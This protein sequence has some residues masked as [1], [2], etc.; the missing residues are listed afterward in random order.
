MKKRK[1]SRKPRKTRGSAH[2][3]NRR[4]SGGK[5]DLVEAGK[6]TRFQPGV[7]GNLAGRP[8]TKIFRQLAREIVEMVDTKTKK[9]RARRLVE[10]L[11]KEAEKGSLGHFKEI[12]RL[13]EEDS[14]QTRFE[15][16]AEAS[17]P[18]AKLS[19]HETLARIRQIYGLSDPDHPGL[20]ETSEFAR[21]L[22]Q[23]RAAAETAGA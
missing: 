14:T 22:E 10:S 12:H 2:A 20:S 15:L 8:R 18:A 17:T 9:E 16:T 1:P 19:L 21:R 13:L 23:E 4:V 5:P 11:F 7:S 6:A 3:R